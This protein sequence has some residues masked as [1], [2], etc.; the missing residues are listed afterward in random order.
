M[1]TFLPKNDLTP[2]AV[3]EFDAN[4]VFIDEDELILYMVPASNKLFSTGKTNLNPITSLSP[5]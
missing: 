2:V 3:P 1:A 4:A 5:L